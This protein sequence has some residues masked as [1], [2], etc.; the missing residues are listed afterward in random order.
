M[1]CVR[2]LGVPSELDE[3]KR[4]VRCNAKFGA[5]SLMISMT[6]PLG[7]TAGMVLFLETLDIYIAFRQ[8]TER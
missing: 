2:A 1:N 7:W 8:V 5:A 4:R 3:I 6:C